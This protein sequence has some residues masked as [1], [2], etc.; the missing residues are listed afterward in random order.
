M[1]YA[2]STGKKKSDF[3][4]KKR[5]NKRCVPY[6]EG[7]DVQRYVTNFKGWHL[8]YQP[9]IMARPTFR[10]LHE[11]PKLLVRALAQGLW[12]TRDTLQYYADQKLICCVQYGSLGEHR[13][14]RPPA[15]VIKNSKY[16]DRYI[17]G[18]LNSCVIGY[19]YR[20]VLFSGLSILP[21]DVRRLPIRQINFS[22][23][24]DKR[25]HDSLVKLVEKMLELQKEFSDLE[26]NYDNKR[27]LIKKQI[28]KVDAE[29]DALVYDL[30][31]LSSDEI[32][33]VQNSGSK[34]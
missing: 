13:Q 21:E 25:K 30:Y 15:D 23:N 16:D 28:D 24:D 18:L 17:L 2:E 27:P 5:V 26:R 31:E 10:E 32:A 14:V 11:S 8:D 4:H 9:D 12:G 20:V 29:I 33:V 1:A 22:D 19:Y 34:S 3:L 6:L 7:K